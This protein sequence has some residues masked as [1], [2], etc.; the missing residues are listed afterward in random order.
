MEIYLHVFWCGNTWKIKLLKCKF[1]WIQ[2][3]KNE[4]TNFLSNSKIGNF[5]K[6]RKQTFFRSFKLHYFSFLGCR[7]DTL[8]MK[9]KKEFL[10]QTYILCVEILFIAAIQQRI[11]PVITDTSHFHVSASFQHQFSDLWVFCMV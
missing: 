1:G 6:N 7:E 3:F 8:K 4:R 10:K 11:P 2:S 9:L 5:L